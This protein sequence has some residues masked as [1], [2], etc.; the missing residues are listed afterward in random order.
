MEVSHEPPVPSTKDDPLIGE[1]ALA[2]NLPSPFNDPHA[3][4]INP[5]TPEFNP[6]S[7]SYPNSSFSTDT[8]TNSICSDGLSLKN[9]P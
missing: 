2:L 1:Q 9:V 8:D 5:Q 3:F 6:E 4:R 7:P